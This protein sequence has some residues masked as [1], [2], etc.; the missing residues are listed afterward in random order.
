MKEMIWTVLFGFAL[1]MASQAPFASVARAEST[2]EERVSAA[3][4]AADHEA[5]AAEYDKLAQEAK[6][7]SVMHK[8]LSA[9]YSKAGVS[10]GKGG[11]ASFHAMHNHCDAL[12]KTYATLAQEYE[13]LAKDHLAMAKKL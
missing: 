13:Q 6:A 10:N 8:D 11:Q 9:T 4:T 3:K 5:I 2:I 7:K 12:G 1:A